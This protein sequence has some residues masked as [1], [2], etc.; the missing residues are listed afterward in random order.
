MEDPKSARIKN[1]LEHI[2]AYPELSFCLLLKILAGC[3]RSFF[4]TIVI[5][6]SQAPLHIRWLGRDT[7]NASGYADHR[8]DPVRHTQ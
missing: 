8:Q 3:D 1:V 6:S 4:S 5:F 7:W 2:A